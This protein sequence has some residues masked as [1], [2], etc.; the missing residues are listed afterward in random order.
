MTFKYSVASVAKLRYSSN[1]V[2]K[3]VTVHT[4]ILEIISM[5]I[6]FHRVWRVLNFLNQ[7]IIYFVLLGGEY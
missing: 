7:I 3:S 1:F 2:I 6:V 4:E 5:N